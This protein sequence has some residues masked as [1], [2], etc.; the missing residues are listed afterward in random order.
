MNEQFSLLKTIR[1]TYPRLPFQK[2]KESVLGKRYN[3]SVVLI[4]ETR[5][6]SLNKKYRHKKKVANILSFPLGRDSGEIFITPSQVKK[7]ARKEEMEYKKFF[8]LIFIHGLL[9]L[10]GRAHGST[11]EKQENKWLKK[12]G[13]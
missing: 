7:D 8:A 12:Y 6:A 1:S 9:H 3:L 5:S 2:I 10:K 11:M 4:G 13:F